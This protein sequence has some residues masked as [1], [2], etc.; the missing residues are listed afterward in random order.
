[1]DWPARSPETCPEG[2]VEF[3]EEKI[4]ETMSG[5]LCRSAAYVGIPRTLFLRLFSWRCVLE[6]FHLLVGAGHLTRRR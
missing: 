4:S 3:S 1:M 2:P 6:R 5:N